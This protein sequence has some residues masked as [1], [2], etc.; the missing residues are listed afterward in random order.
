MLFLILSYLTYGFAEDSIV[1]RA[2]LAIQDGLN[3]ET[4]EDNLIDESE[5]E[6]ETEELTD[7]DISTI[8]NLG[9]DSIE[10]AVDVD[11]EEASPL[12]KL[13]GERFSEE[14]DIQTIEPISEESEDE[15]ILLQ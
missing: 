1:E 5:A 10:E 12:E 2:E 6:T 15:G 13:L 3:L 9:D 14:E 7:E 8:E 11:E 4:M